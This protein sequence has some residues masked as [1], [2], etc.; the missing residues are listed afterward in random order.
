[1]AKPRGKPWETGHPT[2]LSPNV[3]IRGAAV[4]AL[5]DRLLPVDDVQQ[6][7]ALVAQELSKRVLQDDHRCRTVTICSNR[8]LE[9]KLKAG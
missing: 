9:G 5:I 8:H 3:S 4:G 6:L 2:I 7:Y 1:M